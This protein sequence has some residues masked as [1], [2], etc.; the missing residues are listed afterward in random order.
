[1]RFRSSG[2][3]LLA[4]SV[5]FL[6]LALP[7][8]AE[9]TQSDLVI[10][11]ADDIIE[12]DLYAVG[13]RVQVEGRIEGD[14]YAAAFEEVNISGEVT[15]D[16][17]VVS[18]RLVIS[19]E[20]GGSV[21]VAAGT[22]VVDGDVGDDLAVAAWNTGL[23]AQGSVGRDLINWGRNG[24]IAGHVGRDVLGRFSRL[25][26]D[27]QVAG[28]VEIS[29]G[30]LNVGAG[31]RVEGDLGYR[32]SSS[33]EINATD[34]GGSVIHRSPLPPNIRVRALQLLTFLLAILMLT[35][36]GLLLAWAWPALFEPAIAAAARGWSTWL[37]GLGIAASPL[38]AA[39]LLGL[40]ISLSPPQAGIPLAIVFLPVILGLG[41]LVL[42]GSLLGFIPVAG[43]L[44]RR[45]LPKRSN[46]GEVLAGMT[47]IAV[48]LLV[49]VVRLLVMAIVVPL[50]IGAWVLRQK[51]ATV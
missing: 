25:Q 13:N 19:G 6:G 47:I 9:L 51:Q 20:V 26:L 10:V 12:E 29:V 2:A 18:S 14:L 41:G 15:G 46:A 49:P 21:R 36:G 35:A 33:A 43:A 32:S 31:A 45:L 37:G 3:F 50:G 28:S 34:L 22:V 17:V 48:L 38:I 40:L 44:G 4:A 23:G 42:F 16:V 11:Q 24:S 39:G 7:A 5:L 30:R 1:M 27:G 8:K